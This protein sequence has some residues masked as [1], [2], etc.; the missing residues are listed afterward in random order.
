MA[1]NVERAQT[2]LSN[3]RSVQPLLGALRTISLGSWQSALKQQQNM[4]TYRKKFALMLSA[5]TPL[6]AARK[7][8]L[9][10]KLG[11]GIFWK[12]AQC[13]DRNR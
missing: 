2:R 9:P 12:A 10:G 13:S 8:E 6:I 1:D 11:V 7:K 4:K 5:L 3:I